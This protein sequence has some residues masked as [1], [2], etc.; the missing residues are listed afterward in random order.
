MSFR[1]GVQVTS[2]K[3]TTFFP[4]GSLANANLV[5][6]I[7]GNVVQIKVG[8]QSQFNLSN[9]CLDIDDFHALNQVKVLFRSSSND[10]Q[11]VCF[12]N[13][14]STGKGGSGLPPVT[15]VNMSI[16]GPC[17]MEWKVEGFSRRSAKDLHGVHVI[18]NVVLAQDFV[19]ARLSDAVNGKQKEMPCAESSTNKQT[20]SKSEASST[21][22]RKLDQHHPDEIITQKQQQQQQD[23]TA[24]TASNGETTTTNNKS[25]TKLTKKQR[26]QLAQ[27]KSKQLE[28]TLS[29]A[30]DDADES[31]TSNNKKSKKKQ[32]K[33]NDE[34]IISKPTSLTRERRLP[35]GILLRDILLG[36]GTPVNSGRRISLHYTA[37]L[38]SNG[39]VF[40]KNYSKQHPLVFRQGTGEVIRGLERGLEGM[41][42]GGERVISVPSALGYGEKGSGESIPPN[43]DLVFE[44]KVLKVG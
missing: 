32:S 19:S 12:C 27:E 7:D 44:V 42:V 40:D 43:S 38:A 30:R 34:T 5:N 41:K 13:F 18:G 26:K 31:T 8:E 37:T 6:G 4:L 22:K 14:L 29:A 20:P 3:T 16:A 17:V 25:A 24:D 11:W 9:V 2:L 39:K 10:N 35:G 23:T 33:S 1:T 28:E 36:T 15:S 21:K